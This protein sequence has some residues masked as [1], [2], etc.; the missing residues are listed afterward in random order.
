MPVKKYGIIY[1]LTGP[2]GKIYIGLTTQSLKRRL[3]QH[4][5]SAKNHQIKK[6][7]QYHDNPQDNLAKSGQQQH[8]S[9]AICKYGME[10]F[11]V[12]VLGRFGSKDELNK[13]EIKYIKQF[14][15]FSEN[16]NG[17]NLT[18]GGEG[19]LPNQEVRKKMS[20]SQKHRY[21]D[22]V[23]RKRILELMKK[24]F[25]KPEAIASRL[26]AHSSAEVREKK[27]VTN[28]KTWALLDVKERHSSRMKKSHSRASVRKKISVAT[29][30]AMSRPEIKQRQLTA[31]NRADV[32]LKISLA[33]KGRKVSAETKRKISEKHKGKKLSN[34]HKMKISIANKSKPKITCP[35]CG[36]TGGET[37]MKSWHF[38]NCRHVVESESLS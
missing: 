20:E 24:N 26:A 11:N 28:K 12:E 1:K 37:G 22:P 35:H 7:Q 14:N 13:A 31:L 4:R 36:R 27:S 23:E 6:D 30:K 15:S 33:N 25:N 32:K 18:A 38:A 5:H 17:Y 3:Q 19:G 8:L 9:S 10:S 16:G 29:K 34:D 2:T 21:E